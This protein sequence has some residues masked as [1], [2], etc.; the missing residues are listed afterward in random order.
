MFILITSRQH[1]KVRGSTPPAAAFFMHSVNEKWK[2]TEKIIKAATQKTIPLK[3]RHRIVKWWEEKCTRK[4]EE[5]NQL[6]T[7]G[8]QNKIDIR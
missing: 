7:K 6:R 4:T 2:Q 1:G 3:K 5:R 8:I